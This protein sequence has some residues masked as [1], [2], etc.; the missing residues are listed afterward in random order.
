MGG[1]VLSAVADQVLAAVVVGRVASLEPILV[2]LK[3]SL[4][5]ANLCLA[6]AGEHLDRC[7]LRSVSVVHVAHVV[8]VHFRLD[9]FALVVRTVVPLSIHSG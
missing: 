3:Y 5:I 4:Q 7:R 1:V 6:F 9:V 2:V 8:P